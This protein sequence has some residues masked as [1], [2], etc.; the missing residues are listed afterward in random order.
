MEKINKSKFGYLK[1]SMKLMNTL[2]IQIV[3]KRAENTH[4]TNIRNAKMIL[5]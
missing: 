2:A 3:K 1:R 4:I 5:L